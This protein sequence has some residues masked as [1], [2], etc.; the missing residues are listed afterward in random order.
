MV[1][2]GRTDR[3]RTMGKI[4]IAEAI[5]GM[6]IEDKKYTK[7]DI[8]LWYCSVSEK[9]K[10]KNKKTNE[11]F[12]EIGFFGSMMKKE[13]EEYKEWLKRSTIGSQ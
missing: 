13:V 2:D 9:F 3:E 5:G 8:V 10:G 6:V 1:H 11:E 7:G 12:D 4:T